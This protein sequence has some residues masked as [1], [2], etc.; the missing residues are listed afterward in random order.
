MAEGERRDIMGPNSD[1]TEAELALVMRE[2]RDA[3][4]RR[5]AEAQERMRQRLEDAVETA[6][7]RPQP[8]E[9]P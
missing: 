1:P 4:V 8:P 5:W 7:A 9:V 3:A 2:A 6:L